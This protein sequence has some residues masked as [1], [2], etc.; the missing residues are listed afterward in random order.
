MK[1]T[2]KILLMILVFTLIT[3][4]IIPIA[5]N[6]VEGRAK[7]TAS[8]SCSVLSLDLSGSMKKD[9]VSQMKLAAK[10]FAKQVFEKDANSFISVIVY[11]DNATLL[12]DL[13]NS[14]DEVYAAIDSIGNVG[15]GNT[16][17]YESLQLAKDTLAS[18]PFGAIKNIL[19]FTDGTPTVGPKT[20][21]GQYKKSDIAE[22]QYCNSVA[23]L[24]EEMMGNGHNIY[25]VGF[26]QDVTTETRKTFAQ[27]FLNNVQNSGY[28]DAKN[29]DEL[30]FAFEKIASR[31][32]QN[33]TI[34]Y[35]FTF[36]SD[37]TKNEKKAVFT[38]TGFDLLF[39]DPSSKEINSKLAEISAI[40]AMT[41]SYGKY[42]KKK[43]KK[44]TT[45]D[46][47]FW[48]TKELL[49][50][51]NFKQNSSVKKE[52]TGAIISHKQLGDQYLVAII[53][54]STDPNEWTS[55]FNI[56]KNKNNKA[57]EHYGF[58]KAANSIEKQVNSYIKKNKIE[59]TTKL[60]ITGHSR[61]AAVANI[62][63]ADYSA[64]NKY[65]KENVYA[66]TFATPNV[67]KLKSPEKKFTNIK[68]FVY[69][70]D[71]VTRVPLKKWGYKKNGIFGA[72]NEFKTTNTKL[73]KGMQKEFKNMLKVKYKNNKTTKQITNLVN[74][75]GK[76]VP[77]VKS[78][79]RLRE[80]GTQSVSNSYS[81]QALATLN[82]FLFSKTKSDKMNKELVKS[83]KDKKE[84][85]KT[86][87]SIRYAHTPETYYSW[88]KAKYK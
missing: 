49:K 24:A 42:T 73:Y 62:I 29:L 22:Y 23:N 61:G 6:A 40:S 84:L 17:I 26:F 12:C 88:I 51:L 52:K 35:T 70:N 15:K 39:L 58:R 41:G 20:T 5:T 18:V 21:S 76:I 31:V 11:S 43:N 82:V 54:S 47:S 56:S 19:L 27:N 74:E 79:Y 86:I 80:K 10:E 13:S 50:K 83:K 75:I 72:K 81:K 60:W 25:S 67:A 1:K 66:Y 65:G 87:E 33:K 32:E 64:N 3:N 55:N 44:K 78:F 9:S 59:G 71:I 63:A 36:Y 69:E 30:F 16:N 46:T 14:I 77:S 34:S 68:N 38:S 85:T 28:Y 4:S 53:C 7:P 48:Y 57:K 2:G 8:S 45:N 37:I